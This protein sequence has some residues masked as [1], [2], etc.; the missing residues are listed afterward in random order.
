MVR[1]VTL[2]WEHLCVLAGTSILFSP[3]PLNLGRCPSIAYGG[4]ADS[5]PSHCCS[6]VNKLDSL[7][8]GG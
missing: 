7:W 5:A 2:G 8:P 4:D 3:V 1:L 6:Q